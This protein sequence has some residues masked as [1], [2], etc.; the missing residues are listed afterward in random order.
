MPTTPDKEP[1]LNDIEAAKELSLSPKTLRRWRWLG[2]GP[3]FLKLGGCVRYEPAT[4]R[5]FKAASRRQ[6][7]TEAA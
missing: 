3:E 6:S 2:T 7:T 5:S 4:L 1:L